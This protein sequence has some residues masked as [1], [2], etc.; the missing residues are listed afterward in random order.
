MSTQ[1]A[2]KTLLEA[3]QLDRSFGTDG[4]TL[5]EGTEVKA[6]AVLKAEG[7]DQGKVIGVINTANDF[8]L[9]R[10]K[11]DGALDH[12][13]GT[14][15]YAR[16]GFGGTQ[17]RSIPTGIVE[18]SDSK[19]LL[20]GHVLEGGTFGNYYPAAARVN[21]KG[22]PDLTFGQS[23]V[24]T[25]RDQPPTE[26]QTPAS[27]SQETSAIGDLTV[28]ETKAG[29]ILF[30]ANNSDGKP[31]RN[32]GLLI[33]LTSTGELDNTFNDQGY[34]F[35]K[36]GGQNTSSIGS[37]T[38][39]SGRIIVAG[40]TATQGFLAGFTQTGKTDRSFGTNGF[41]AFELIAGRVDL[42]QLLLQTD[43]KPVVIGRSGTSSSN[44]FVTRTD[45]D[46]NRDDTFNGGEP[47]I[48]K[49]PFQA[50]QWNSGD[51]DSI[52]SI[53]VGGELSD[54]GL[55]LVGRIT[56]AGEPDSNFGKNGLSDPYASGTPNY[57]TSAAVQTET[58][59][60]IAGRKDNIPS[61]SRYQA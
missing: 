23:G 44:G 58:Q 45:I 24:F 2:S 10:L 13:F 12:T 5:L 33:R 55:G 53:I 34:A 40:S 41:T 61:V 18:L 54:R 8:I 47:L 36:F 25:F 52:G 59:I 39:T 15:G 31:Y 20:T 3:G 17:T 27:D 1:N 35:F 22:S 9:F 30:S 46:G 50:S 51:I 4:T 21:A 16:W 57:T 38:Q 28:V 56:K 48:T 42:R 19:I 11:K 49:Y 7:V 26:G 14:N 32:W 60:V 29:K 6:L 43:N 37:V